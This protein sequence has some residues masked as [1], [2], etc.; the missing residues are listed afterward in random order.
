MLKDGEKGAV[1]QRDKTTYAIVPHFPCGVI[2]PEKLRRVAEVAEKYNCVAL[3]LT[4]AERIAM[5]GIKEE[6]IDAVWQDLG[7]DP[8]HAVG[9]CV[10][11]VKVCPG[12]TFCRIA[13]QDSLGIGMLL[14]QKYHGMPLPGKFKIGVSGCVN[15]CVETCIKDI[16]LI[17]KSKGWTLKAGGNGTA[18]PRLALELAAD[19]DQDA[20]LQLI[21]KV[22]AFYSK[23]AKPNE[24]LGATIERVGF[25]ELK[26]QVLG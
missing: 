10:R 24:R 6:D 9:L 2:T 13:Q 18:K 20:A 25:E 12:T 15:D 19:L 14:D 7:I 16:G 8:G 1:L 23:Q 17:G 21:E 11:S 4:S 22:V 5:V 3:K 26:K